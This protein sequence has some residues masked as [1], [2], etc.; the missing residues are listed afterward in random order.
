[1]K[2]KQIIIQEMGVEKFSIFI[3]D[4]IIVCSNLFKI[5]YFFYTDNIVGNHFFNEKNIYSIKMPITHTH[6]H[7]YVVYQ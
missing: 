2:N 7:M 6:T 1:M 3:F 5:I 4:N